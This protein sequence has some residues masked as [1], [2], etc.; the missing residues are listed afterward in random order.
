MCRLD[1]ATVESQEFLTLLPATYGK[2]AA[3]MKWFL[4]SANN[5]YRDGAGSA[6]DIAR[7]RTVAKVDDYE[8]IEFGVH[9]GGNDGAAVG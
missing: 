5:H 6:A 7:A 3:R 9:V 8:V 1:H 4:D 2:D